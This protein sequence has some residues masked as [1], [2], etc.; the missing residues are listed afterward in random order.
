MLSET[1]EA[2]IGI[3]SNAVKETCFTSHHTQVTQSDQSESSLVKQP[4][5][6]VAFGTA[7]MF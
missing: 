5:Q 7:T 3:A 6:S 2:P 1:P 4:L